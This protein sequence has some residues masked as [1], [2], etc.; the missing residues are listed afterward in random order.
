MEKENVSFTPKEKIET[1]E[2]NNLWL[3]VQLY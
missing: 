2:T 1:L 3:E